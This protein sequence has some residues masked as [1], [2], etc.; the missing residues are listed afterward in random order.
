MQEINDGAFDCIKKLVP[1][2]DIKTA[3]DG[4]DVAIL[5]GAFPRKKGMLRADLLK[6]NANIFKTQGAAL[7][8]YASRNVKVVVVGNPANTNATVAATYAPDLPRKNFTAMTRLDQNRA[9]SM[10]A[11]RLGCDTTSLKN[12]VIWGNHSKTM[13]PDVNH[14]YVVGAF[15]GKT[16]LR[17]AVADSKWLNGP[18][19]KTV[20]QRGSAII[21][22][23][24]ASSAASAANA[25]CDHIRDWYFGTKPGQYVNMAVPSDGSYGVPKGI[26]YSFP[27]VTKNFEYQ[28]VQGLS[29]DPFSRK[30]MDATA[31]ELLQ[32]KKSALE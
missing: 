12:V 30:L 16:P 8:K 26:I 31:A 24:G 1:T 7:N 22:A 20:Q 15:N 13:Y 32:E 28:I 23:R 5:V 14:G 29:I 4:V 17:E 2:T 9:M 25:A 18:F 11:T 6:R 10:L 21:K 27:C 19:I 3:F